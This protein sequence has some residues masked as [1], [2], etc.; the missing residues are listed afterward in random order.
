M[1]GQ[2]IRWHVAKADV[3]D[4][5]ISGMA[6]Q[7]IATLQQGHA[8]WVCR[9]LYYICGRSC[10]SPCVLLRASR[11]WISVVGV[12]SGRCRSTTQID[13]HPSRQNQSLPMAN[14]SSCTGSVAAAVQA[15]FFEACLLTYLSG[16][17]HQ[18]CLRQLQALSECSRVEVPEVLLLAVGERHPWTSN[19]TTQ[20][21]LAR[22]KSW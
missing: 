2:N 11:C 22:I 7:T 20:A 1:P 19:C 8:S 17:K 13:A 5:G 18:D 6:K 3:V 14:A 16:A 4:S 10:S 15:G 9:L 21:P 12:V